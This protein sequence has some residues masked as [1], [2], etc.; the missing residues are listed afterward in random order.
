MKQLSPLFFTFVI[1]IG[2]LSGCNSKPE[3]IPKPAGYMRVDFPEKKYV[4]YETDCPFSFKIPTYAVVREK[5]ETEADQCMKNII[6]GNLRATLHCTY[7]AIQSPEDFKEYSEY[8]RKLAY[9]HR[10][11][12]DAIDQ[13]VFKNP[14]A[15][16]YGVIYEI[17]G[18]AACN[19][20]FYLSDST[21]NY[22]AGSLYFLSAPNA[23]SLRPVL[24]FLKTDIR[25]LVETFRWK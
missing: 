9:E 3:F 2:L 22:F 20:Q 19:Y 11:K 18:N 5:S 6:F 24:D 10:V 12:A 4:V 8:T 1:S 14:E 17:E 23:D 13:I 15:S 16:V 7:I 25:H 21:K